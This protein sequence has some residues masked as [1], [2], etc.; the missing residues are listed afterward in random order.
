VVC[1]LLQE[2]RPWNR[3]VWLST[4]RIGLEVST[5]YVLRNPSAC[6]ILH[7]STLAVAVA[8]YA[9]VSATDANFGVVLDALNSSGYAD[10]TIIVLI[11]DHGVGTCS[12]SH[13]LN[14]P[15]IGVCCSGNLVI[16]GSLAR[17]PTLNELL[18]LL[19][20]YTCHHSYKTVRFGLEC[21]AV[22]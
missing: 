6:T 9:S 7:S 22:V 12:Y 4:R 3:R 5:W 10:N 8:Y 17:K 20:S 16:W 11:G 1:L 14:S 15:L 18:E 2:L 19:L 13:W 21:P